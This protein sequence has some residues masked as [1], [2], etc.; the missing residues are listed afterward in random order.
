[1]A[2]GSRQPGR[3]VTS[4]VLAI[5]S[6]FEQSRGSLSLTQIANEADLPSVTA[7]RV[8]ISTVST[9][10]IVSPGPRGWVAGYH[11]MAPPSANA[12]WRFLNPGLP[13]PISPDPLKHSPCAQHGP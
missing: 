2:G 1:M 12:F 7:P 6:T 9:G 13:K 10:P 3:S 4:K 11:C 8:S 5:L